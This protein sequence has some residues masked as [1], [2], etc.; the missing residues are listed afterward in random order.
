MNIFFFSFLLEVESFVSTG[1]IAATAGVFVRSETRGG[2]IGLREPVAMTTR[3]T[4]IHLTG[5]PPLFCPSCSR[6]ILFFLHFLHIARGESNALLM[7]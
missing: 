2:K 3:S 5:L 7:H 4:V 1:N 6:I